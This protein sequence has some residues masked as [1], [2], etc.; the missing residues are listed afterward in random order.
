[1]YSK[2]LGIVIPAY[3]EARRISSSIRQVGEYFR[4][5]KSQVYIVYVIEKSTDQ[6]LEIARKAARDY[7]FIEILDQGV[8][9][10]KGFAVR[11]GVLHLAKRLDPQSLVM[12]MDCDLSTPLKHVDDLLNFWQMRPEIQIVIGNRKHPGSTIGRSQSWIR[13]KMGEVFNWLVQG[14]TG[15]R[16]I[17]DTQCGFKAF[18]MPVGSKL[19]Q[20]LQ[21]NGFAF[22]VEILLRARRLGLP[23]A[24]IPVSWFDQKGSKVRIVRDSLKMLRAILLLRHRVMSE[25][26]EL[27]EI[28]PSKA[29]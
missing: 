6:T 28:S 16:G 24:S 1:M 26:I 9:R 3:Q 22:D 27:E 25:K 14:I 19:F 20:A 12:F 10:G 8:Q 17:R 2:T 13:R 18:R 21:E 11:T 29:A 15:L 4:T 23:T 7:S 5:R